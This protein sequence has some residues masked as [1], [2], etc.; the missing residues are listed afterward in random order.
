MGFEPRKPAVELY[1]GTPPTP[2]LLQHQPGHCWYYSHWVCVQHSRMLVLLV[3]KS[4]EE[5]GGDA[6]FKLIPKKIL[7][8]TCMILWMEAHYIGQ[9]E[10][11]LNG[12]E[13]KP[14]SDQ[15]K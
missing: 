12:M 3:G 2:L 8:R 10:T 13:R 4:Q 9:T 11:V 5:R 1:H 7:Q 14:D 15:R 6:F